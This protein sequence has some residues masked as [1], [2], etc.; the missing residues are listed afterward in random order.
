MTQEEKLLALVCAM[1]T[2]VTTPH[3]SLIR[4]AVQSAKFALAEIEREAG[5]HD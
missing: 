5:P 2:G 1:L 4:Q 3:D